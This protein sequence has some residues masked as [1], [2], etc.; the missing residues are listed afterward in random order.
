MDSDDLISKELEII[1]NK[2]KK[3][4]E[5]KIVTPPPERRFDPITTLKQKAGLEVQEEF[6]SLKLLTEQGLKAIL[7]T[8][9]EMGKKEEGETIIAWFKSHPD[10]ILKFIKDKKVSLESSAEQQ[11]DFPRSSLISMYEAAQYLFKKQQYEDAL[12]AISVCLQFNFTLSPLWFTYGR[13]FQ[14]MENHNMAL[15][16][17]QIAIVF[18][19]ENPLAYAYMARSWMAL[20][21]WQHAEKALADARSRAIGKFADDNAFCDELETW[22]KTYRHGR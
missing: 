16:A 14:E 10:D 11:L 20:A 13:I 1:Q 2:V 17:F 7:D 22:M 18:D 21:E 12:A 6:N 8:L 3:D 15:Y 19:D 5:D 4:A 9:N